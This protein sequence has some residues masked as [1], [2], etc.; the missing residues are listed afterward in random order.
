M[1]EGKFTSYRSRSRSP[2]AAR[3]IP[4][5]ITQVSLLL[6]DR[7]GP[8][9]AY[10][11]SRKTTAESDRG[12]GRFRLTV[13]RGAMDATGSPSLRGLERLRRSE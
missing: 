2:W 9:I 13:L 8:A 11:A 10:A 1:V 7:T 12:R 6:K 5:R 4:S 3:I